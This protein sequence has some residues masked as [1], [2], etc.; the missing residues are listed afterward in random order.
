MGLCR[1]DVATETWLTGDKYMNM[2]CHDLGFCYE[3]MFV[4]FVSFFVVRFSLLGYT[5][6]RFYA[7]S[8]A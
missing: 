4:L 6:V 1:N 2:C 7:K 3:L 5:T 8:L